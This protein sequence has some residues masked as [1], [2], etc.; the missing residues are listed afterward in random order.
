MNPFNTIKIPD[1]LKTYVKYIWASKTNEEKKTGN[2]LSIFADGSPGII[3]QQSKMGM[4]LSDGK[5]LSSV[6]LYGQIVEPIVLNSNDDNK[7]I[8]VI[9]HPHVLKTIFKFDANEIT[10]NCIDINLTPGVPGINLTDQLWNT[11]SPEKQVTLMFQYLNCL[12]KN[13]NAIT[14]TALQYAAT[15]I[16]GLHGNVSLSRIQAELNISQRTLERKFEQ[17]VGISPKLLSSIA[18]FQAGLTQLKHNRFY[19]LSDI[20]YDNGYSDQSH[21]IRSFKKFTGL[22]PLKFYRQLK[23]NYANAPLNVTQ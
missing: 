23:N 16:M 20:A 21:F 6:F 9:F 19:K 15:Q 11:D 8:V 2:S 10:D 7:M 13:N 18:Q 4:Y 1:N 17:H 3:F 12:I 14:D 22:S 5:K